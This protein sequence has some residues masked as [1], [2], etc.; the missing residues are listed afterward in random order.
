MFSG[1]FLVQIG[2]VQGCCHRV[3]LPIFS[4][5]KVAGPQVRDQ[6]A[7]FSSGSLLGSCDHARLPRTKLL[8]QSASYRFHQALERGLQLPSP[9]ASLTL[10]LTTSDHDNNNAMRENCGYA[11][12]VDC[13]QSG[14]TEQGLAD[15]FRRPVPS[16]PR[17][18]GTN[19]LSQQ[20][21]L[22]LISSAVFCGK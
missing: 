16:K 3:L 11:V 12:C 9:I 8:S 17:E 13:D 5:Q 10:D 19:D 1:V 18:E 4:P 14:G 21:L 15:P 6:A 20:R 22:A 2:S 7:T